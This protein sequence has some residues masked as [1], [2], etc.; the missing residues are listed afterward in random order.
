[1]PTL[2][3][4][5][6][7]TADLIIPQNAT[8][9]F[10]I[11][12][13]DKT[14]ALIDHEGWTFDIRLQGKADTSVNYIWNDYVTEIEPGKISV[15]IPADV[16]G[17]IPVGKYNWDIFATDPYGVSKRLVYG[18]ATVIDTYAKD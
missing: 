6:L 4:K 18:T 9:P 10:L 8:F 1:M 16:T 12:H 17:S 11:E 3:S 15:E 13:Y 2:G 7:T 14:D 5:G